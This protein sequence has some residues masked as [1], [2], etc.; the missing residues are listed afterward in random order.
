MPQS[1]FDVLAAMGLPGLVIGWL[2]LEL[3][4]ERVRVQELME[5]RVKEAQSFAATIRE[6]DEKRVQDERERGDKILEIQAAVH[7]SIEELS[8]VTDLLAREEARR[9]WRRN[10]G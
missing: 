3:R 4:R 10:D 7:G 6:V 2:A 9:S 8:K 1:F 5:I